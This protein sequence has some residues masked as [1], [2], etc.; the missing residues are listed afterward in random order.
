MDENTLI[1][2]VLNEHNVLQCKPIEVSEVYHGLVLSCIDWLYKKYS[3]ALQK[4]ITSTWCDRHGVSNNRTIECL[5]NSLFRLT[6]GDIKGPRYWPFVRG[7][8]R[9]P[10][11]SPHTGP[12]TRKIFTFFDI[13]NDYAC[14]TL[15]S[16][17]YMGNAWRRLCGMFGCFAW[18]LLKSS[19]W[20]L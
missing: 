18:R 1:L 3:P 9:W 12:V 6:T 19:L 20:I 2:L 13:I 16:H 7:I 14:F 5:F 8:H 11:D 10:V 4:C 17:V 15:L